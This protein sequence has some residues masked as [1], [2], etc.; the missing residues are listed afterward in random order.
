MLLPFRKL[1]PSSPQFIASQST[2]VLSS[3]KLLPVVKIPERV[4]G[5][6]PS[7]G[8]RRFRR[9]V[10]ENKGDDEET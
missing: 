7:S 4:E 2:K 3:G 9:G 1:N 6:F 8:S 5:D 10:L